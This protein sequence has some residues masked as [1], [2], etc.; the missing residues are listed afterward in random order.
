MSKQ[1]KNASLGQGDQEKQ[2]VKVSLMKTLTT[3]GLAKVLAYKNKKLVKLFIERLKLTTT[4]AE[5]LLVDTLKFLFL[6]ASTNEPLAPPKKIDDAWHLFILC[7]EDYE[8]FCRKNL[9]FFIHHCP[10]IEG[11]VEGVTEDL[12]TLHYLTLAKVQ[13]LNVLMKT[14][15]LSRNFTSGVDAQEW[16]CHSRRE[17]SE[18]FSS[19][20]DSKNWC[21]PRCSNHR[22]IPLL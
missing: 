8:N 20:L 22:I 9:G 21:T 4:E 10:A 12:E 19:G 3:N 7:T 6:C 15:G 17:I 2:G 11:K 13:E 16:C 18:N 14:G 1:N 5:Q